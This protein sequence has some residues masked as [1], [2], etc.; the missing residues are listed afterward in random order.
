MARVPDQAEIKACAFQ[1]SLEKAPGPD[2]LTEKF[3]QHNWDIMGPD[4]I[5]IIQDAFDMSTAPPQWM[6]CNV[7]LIPKTQ[8]PKTL[9]DYRLISIGNILYRLIAKII[10]NRFQPHMNKI[11]SGAQSAFIRGRSITDNAV[12]MKE[13][14][15]SFN[16]NTQ[17]ENLCVEG[18]YQQS[19]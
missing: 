4:I 5:K 1:L 12:L 6:A 3:I 13:V 2:G 15:H 7:I 16:S 10:T 18:R 14:I 11:I 17:R 8:E 19:I 9:K